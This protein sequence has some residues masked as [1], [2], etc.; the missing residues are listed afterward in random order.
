IRLFN[1]GG[2]AHFSLLRSNRYYEQCTLGNT[3]V[4]KPLN[5]ADL[6]VAFIVL[7]TGFAAASVLFVIEMLYSRISKMKTQTC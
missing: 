4:S 1:E 7:E 2:L 6:M 5:L 3:S